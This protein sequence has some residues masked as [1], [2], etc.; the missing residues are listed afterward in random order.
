[1]DGLTLQQAYAAT[2]E[3][4]L[5]KRPKSKLIVFKRPSDTLDLDFIVHK[6]KSLPQALKDFIAQLNEQGLDGSAQVTFNAYLSYF[7]KDSLTIGAWVPTHEDA[8]AEDWQV[9]DL[10]IDDAV[11]AGQ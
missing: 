3:G 7:D 5:I 8:L 4:K 6:V 1:M 11:K 10:T 2:N 9:L